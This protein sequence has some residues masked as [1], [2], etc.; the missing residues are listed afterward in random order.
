MLLLHK[1]TWYYPQL[2]VYLLYPS[3]LPP[4]LILTKLV[5]H[6]G[7]PYRLISDLQFVSSDFNATVGN[8]RIKSA[9]TGAALSFSEVCDRTVYA[10]GTYSV[11]IKDGKSPLSVQK[12]QERSL[13]SE[14][15]MLGTSGS[16]YSKQCHDQVPFIME[17]D[18]TPNNLIQ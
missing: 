5:F 7:L 10:D 12:R 13:S 9:A 17:A 11:M 3:C 14:K 16:E 15:Y 1:D 18:S 8:E 4:Q 2:Y 6:H